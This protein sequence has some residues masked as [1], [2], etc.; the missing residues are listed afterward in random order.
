M[1]FKEMQQAHET[2]YKLK[3]VMDSRKPLPK[4]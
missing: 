2:F 3:K 1:E 4:L